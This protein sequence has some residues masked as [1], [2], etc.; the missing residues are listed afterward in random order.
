MEYK[1]ADAES[2]FADII[3]DNEP[4]S[5]RQLIQ[6]A[7]GKLGWK[8]TTSYTVLRRLCDRGIFK[9]ENSVVT[10][11]VSREEFYSEKSRQFVDEAFG[12]SLPKFLAAFMGRKNLSK[13]E[14]DEIQ[15][16]IESYGEDDDAVSACKGKGGR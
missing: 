3:W 15:Q 10:S 14:V 4:M 11:C 5:S 1:L 7:E 9:N 2:R 6:M 12:G 13:R 16:L 8:S